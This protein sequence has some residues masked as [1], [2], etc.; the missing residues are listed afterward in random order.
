MIDLDHPP[1]QRR[2]VVPRVGPNNLIPLK[3]Y[4]DFTPPFTEEIMGASISSKFK[5]PNMKTYDG[6]GNPHNHVRTFSN[7]L[8]LQH[9]NDVI[10]C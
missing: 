1:R 8:L 3:D 6:T 5:M 4:D 10:K 9:V 2:N 7:A